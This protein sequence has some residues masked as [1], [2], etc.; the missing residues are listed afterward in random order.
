MSL[1]VFV[2]A[3]LGTQWYLLMD[4]ASPVPP[5]VTGRQIPIPLEV[6]NKAFS[7]TIYTFADCGHTIFFASDIRTLIFFTLMGQVFSIQSPNHANYILDQPT[8]Q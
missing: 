3:S 8:T 7:W 4:K 2:T 1:E 6:M 5:E